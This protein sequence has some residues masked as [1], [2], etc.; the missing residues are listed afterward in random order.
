MS[1]SQAG[2][3]PIPDTVYEVQ[4][5]FPS[6]AALQDAMSQ[7]TLKGYDRADLSLPEVDPAPSETTP[8]QSAENPTTDVDMRQ[9]RTLGAGMAGFLGAAAAAGATIATGGAAGIA[10]AAAAAGG[11]GAVGLAEATGLASDAKQS[12]QRDDKARQGH[13]VL[14]VRTPDHEKAAEVQGIMQRAGATQV[15]P[16]TRADQA[17]TG[18]VN[19]GGWTG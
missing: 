18:G 2:S 13:L 7:L 19:A 4:G 16:V 17:V 15:V 8:E 1:D 12:S 11:A 9:V 6:D 14:A 5:V 3:P 10:I